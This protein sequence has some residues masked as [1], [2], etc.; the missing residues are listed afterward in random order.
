MPLSADKP[1]ADGQTL[2]ILAE[3][4]YLANLLVAPGIAFGVLWWLWRKLTRRA[5]RVQPG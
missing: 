4:L 1:A 2:A 3:A 5:P